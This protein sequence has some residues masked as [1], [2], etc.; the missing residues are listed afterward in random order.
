MA[1]TSTSFH[2]RPD[3]K[4]IG[5]NFRATTGNYCIEVHFENKT[6]AIDA[7]ALESASFTI[8]GDIPQLDAVVAQLDAAL[9][10]L[11]AQVQQPAEVPA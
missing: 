8:W 3:E 7:G 9:T 11:K 2:L 6:R 1:I 5:S 4:V 10:L